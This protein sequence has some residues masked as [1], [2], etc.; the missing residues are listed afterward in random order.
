LKTY[1]LTIATNLARIQVPDKSA[2]DE[3]VD[4]FWNLWGTIRLREV[5]RWVVVEEELEISLS[6]ISEDVGNT[7]AG[8]D[9]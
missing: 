3:T 6:I 8:S 5:Q 7:I 1:F 2:N 9:E 4:V